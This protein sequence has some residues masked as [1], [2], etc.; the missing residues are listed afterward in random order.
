MGRT[1]H[2]RGE[3]ELTVL[4]LYKLLLLM[5]TIPIPGAKRIS[6]S[7]EGSKRSKGKRACRASSVT[8]CRGCLRR[9]ATRALNI[10]SKTKGIA[11]V[12]ALGSAKR[13][14]IR[15]SRRDA[16][17]AAG[18][19]SDRKRAERDR[20]GSLSGAAICDRKASK[21][22][23]PCMDGRGTPRIRNVLMVTSKN[24]GTIIT[25]G[26]ARTIRT[27]FN[28][29]TRGVGVVGHTSAWGRICLGRERDRRGPISRY[30]AYNCSHN[31]EVSRLR[32]ASI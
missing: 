1:S 13:G 9:G 7:A 29:R 27:L 20:R 26:L 16:R 2:N 10:M 8:S 31:D 4:F 3:A 12:V 28:M 15:G 17:R 22:R 19:T 5:I 32:K 18:R 30:N 14:I 6:G 11:I 25:G 21:A 24:K 23:V